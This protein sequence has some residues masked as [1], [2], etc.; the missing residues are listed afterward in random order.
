M[1]NGILQFAQIGCGAFAQ[2]QDLPGFRRHPQIECKWC[3]DVSLERA[4]TLADEYDVPNVTTDFLEIM[5]DPEV[6]AIKNATTH[7]IHLPII[8]AAAAAGKHVFCEKPMA[9]D[10]T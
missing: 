7:E 2:F 10:H 6:D 4:Q 9:L 1:K 3:C 8:E 5:A